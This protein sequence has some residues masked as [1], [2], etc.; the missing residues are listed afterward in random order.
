MELFPTN[1]RQS[2]IG[3]AT[4]ISQTISIGGPYVIYLAQT[5]MKIPY[6]IMCA[7]CAIGAIAVA[8][9]PETLGAKL[10]ETLEEASVFGAKDKFF[11]YLPSKILSKDS[12]QIR[13]DFSLDH[14]LEFQSFS[15]AYCLGF[16]FRVI[17]LRIWLF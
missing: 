16:I 11:S 4:L 5:D 10:P 14:G 15:T 13:I 8:L 3:F 2:G 1:V 12:F 6:L 9:L 17:K 7:V